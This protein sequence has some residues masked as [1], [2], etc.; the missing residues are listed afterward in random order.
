MNRSDRTG[1]RS[2]NN[3]DHSHRPSVLQES[4]HA[5]LTGSK[6]LKGSR[7]TVE[8]LSAWTRSSALYGWL[9][10]EPDPD[11]IVID[12]RETRTVGPVIRIIDRVFAALAAS[13]PSSRVARGGRFLI[14]MFKTRPL[15]LFGAVILVGALGGLLGG[16]LTGT[17][18]VPQ[19]IVLFILAL[20]A[21][22]G[23]RSEI[24]LTELR[25]TALITTLADAFEPPEPPATNRSTDQ[26]NETDDE[27]NSDTPDS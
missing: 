17:L 14:T 4:D 5:V 6:I 12:L 24:P 13:T 2:E 26:R 25:E 3:T 8:R 23:I 19:A 11:V 18:S 22:P 7:T 1:D 10:A 9:T 27:N 20:L 15:K 16:A 21:I